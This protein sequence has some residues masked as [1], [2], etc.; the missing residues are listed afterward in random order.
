MKKKLKTIKINMLCE[1]QLLRFKSIKYLLMCD[2]I[3]ILS[4][5]RDSTHIFF[6]PE[7][8]SFNEHLTIQ[9][10]ILLSDLNIRFITF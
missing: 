3:N 8:Y 4:Q 1:I 10:F 9:N 2:M 7:I 5:S 6:I